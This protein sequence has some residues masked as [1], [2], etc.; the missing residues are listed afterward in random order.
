MDT[1]DPDDEY[2]HRLQDGARAIRH[3]QVFVRALAENRVTPEEFNLEVLRTMLATKS[4]DWEEAL[5]ALPYSL[6]S[7][8]KEYAAHFLAADNMRFISD[9]YVVGVDERRQARMADVVRDILR[10]FVHQFPVSS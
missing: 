6:Q 2:S 4:E 9:P 3:N 1:I 10:R 7:G 5:A 8:L